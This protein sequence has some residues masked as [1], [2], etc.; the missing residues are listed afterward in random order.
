MVTSVQDITKGFSKAAVEELS[1]RR[2]EPDWLRQARLAAWNTYESIPM[3]V[4][5]DEEW[6]RTDIRD[7]PVADV[8]PFVTALPRV[9]TRAE[10]PSAVQAALASAGEL[11]GV[12]VQQDSSTIYH[13]AAANLEEQGIIFV[14]FDTAIARYP[15]LV[16]KYFMLEDAAPADD[17]KFTALHAAFWTTGTFLYI[18]PDVEVELPFHA[19]STLTVPGSASFFHTLIVADENARVTFIDYC[20]S[21]TLEQESIADNVVELR[22]ED[23]AEI[24]YIQ[25]QDW[26]RHVWNFQTQRAVVRQDSAVRSLTVQLG[27]L[28]SKSVIGSQLV[29]PGSQAEMLGLYFTDEDQLVDHH[30]HQNHVAPYAASDL[31]FKGAVKD[32]SRS[33][34]NGTIRVWPKAHGTDAYQANRNLSLSPNARVDTMPRL[35]IGANDVRCTHGATVSKIEEEY[36]FY[37]MSRGI[38]RTEAEKLIVDGFFDEVIERVPVESVQRTVREAIDMK[39]GYLV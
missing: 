36:I 34:Y 33:V 22:A 6:R 8:Q 11:A 13:E 9:T 27:A 21:D 17:N 32:R 15:E 28:F 3:P 18:P 23:G 16:Q 39:I 38:S 20:I 12:V 1:R 29:A 24:R 10:L 35:E 2:N 4:R 14:D 7:L 5:T 19:F 26:G 25:I 31:L 30:T 37:L